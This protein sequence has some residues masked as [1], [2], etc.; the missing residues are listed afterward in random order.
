[1]HA[2]LLSL[3]SISV[4]LAV[5]AMSP[6]PSFIF[7]AKTS[8]ASSRRD[9]LATV[10]GMGVGC[11]ILVLIAFSGLHQ[12]LVTVP[13]LFVTLKI[14][15]GLYLF[16]MAVKIFRGANQPLIFG[17]EGQAEK[18]G[19]GKSFSV[20]L[21]TQLCNPKTVLVLAGIF[22]ALMPRDIPGYFYWVLPA[23]G[24]FIDTLWYTFV[25]FV[26]SSARPQRVY[27][28]YKKSI[29][30]ISGGVMALLGIKLIFTK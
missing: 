4:A 3:F 2:E 12:L 28:R 19:F 15:G 10:L 9:G 24:L 17:P 30:R 1:M 27:L 11:A 8:I 16:S 18:I 21:V 6:G 23:L 14:L 22:A 5:G 7:V 25:A 26:L 20:G 29:S 13:W